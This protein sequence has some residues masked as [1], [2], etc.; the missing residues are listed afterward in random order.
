M[1]TQTNKIVGDE[2]LKAYDAG[3]AALIPPHGSQLWRRVASA[4]I[5][6]PG[7]DSLTEL[8]ASVGR[9][10][11]RLVDWSNW[12]QYE[13]VYAEFQSALI[14][15]NYPLTGRVYSNNYG[16]KQGEYMVWWLARD[17]SAYQS[18]PSLRAAL[19]KTLGAA[20]ADDLLSRLDRYF[21]IQRS[22]AAERR[23]DMSNLGRSL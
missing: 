12:D 5:V 2:K 14:A 9:M 21:P 7:C 11:F 4:D 22:L 16:G 8:T 18:A 1:A 3:D 15:A 20:K 6:S 13:N 19:E 10:E 23:D 17:A